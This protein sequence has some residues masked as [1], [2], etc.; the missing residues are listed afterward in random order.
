MEDAL[1]LLA[2]VAKKLDSASI[3]Y[4]VSGSMAANLYAEP[5]LTN[6]IDIVVQVFGKQSDVLLKLFVG[7]FY[8]T[9]E[10]IQEA[11]SG[12]GMFNI[13]HHRLSIKCDLILLKNDPFSS[14]AFQRRRQELINEYP[15]QFITVEDLIVQK[16]LWRK[17]TGSELQLGDVRRMIALNRHTLDAAYCLHWAQKLGIGSE[18]QS[19]L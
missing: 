17:E 4:M 1:D 5:R 18:L 19:A 13:I 2:H 14:S 8:V 15:V 16:L 11:F 3:P 7:D 9:G 10:L 6:D 12:L